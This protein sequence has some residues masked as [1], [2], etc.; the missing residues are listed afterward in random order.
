MWK[1]LTQDSQ[2]HK[3]FLA[4]PLTDRT[5]KTIGVLRFTEKSHGGHFTE[6]DAKLLRWIARDYIGPAMVSLRLSQFSQLVFDHLPQVIAISVKNSAPLVD[7]PKVLCGTLATFFEERDDRK[8]LYVINI[9]EEGGQRFMHR[10]IGGQWQHLADATRLVELDGT[11]T[12]VALSNTH[13]VFTN[14]LRRAEER[15][16][17]LPL[18]RKAACVL[19]CRVSFL[20]HNYGAIAVYS[21]HHDINPETHGHLLEILAAQAG[22]MYAR[23]ELFAYSFMASGLKHDMAKLL[24]HADGE[25]DKLLQQTVTNSGQP[26]SEQSIEAF[27]NVK[28]VLEFNQYMLDAHYRSEGIPATLLEQD[29]TDFSVREVVK[30]AGDMALK[31]TQSRCTVHYNIAPDLVVRA[32][33]APIAAILFN[34]TKNSA[35][36]CDSPESEITIAAAINHRK[37]LGTWLDI[38]IDDSGPGLS[39]DLVQKYFESDFVEEFF[40]QRLESTHVK[41]FGVYL[42]RRLAY[43]HQFRDGRRAKI[44]PHRRRRGGYRLVVSIPTLPGQTTERTSNM[45]ASGIKVLI[46]DDKPGGSGAGGWADRLEKFGA[47][48][49]P[50][51]GDNSTEL[52]SKLLKLLDNENE[53]FH[54]TIL[55]IMYKSE[56]DGGITLW[57]KF[58]S[59]D[60]VRKSKKLPSLLERVGK[61]IVVSDSG[62]KVK[63]QFARDFAEDRCCFSGVREDRLSH[64]ERWLLALGARDPMTEIADGVRKIQTRLDDFDRRLDSL[65]KKK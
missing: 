34:L 30:L 1:K 14:D 8:K 9:L 24:A 64:V 40:Q 21:S 60:A 13:A 16:A 2:T 25:L 29:V 63:R 48:P 12:A 35:W 28:A 56:F 47:S 50:L 51:I 10:A 43:M 37:G 19:A 58:L 44:T 38:T 4:V 57:K 18:V 39:A 49:T 11:M 65:E 61:L 32:Y 22:E 7:L 6:R 55:D 46:I 53:K 41:G 59:V 54:G 36:A 33:R 27:N 20:N 15:R 17:L 52:L 3:S 26:T 62:D 42:C 45:N 23:Q 5:R 31:E